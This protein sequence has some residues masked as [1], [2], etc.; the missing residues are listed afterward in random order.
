MK[1]TTLLIA[2]GTSIDKNT[3]QWSIFN[4]IETF[5]IEDPEK[6]EFTLRGKFTIVSFWRKEDGDENKFFEVTHELI[7]KKEKALIRQNPIDIEA[8]PSSRNFKQRI[9]LN[10]IPFTGEG[11]Y[12]LR[13]LIREKGDKEFKE[14]S[15]TSIRLRYKEE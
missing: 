6:E 13:S 14:S 11:E 1:N 12:F 9:S 7:D 8:K 4:H 15:R 5:S 2:E 10:K 3:N